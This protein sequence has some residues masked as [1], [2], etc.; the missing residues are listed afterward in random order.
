MDFNDFPP[1][2]GTAKHSPLVPSNVLL[3]QSAETVGSQRKLIPDLTTWMQCFSIYVTVLATQHPQFIPELLAYS[4]DIISASR[5]FKW[6]SWVIY[7]A[8]YRR[9]MAETGQKDW[10]KVDPSIYARC[11][12]GWARPPTWCTVCVTLDH[13]TGDCPYAAVQDRRVRR[14]T[15]YTAGGGGPRS[16][17]KMR[18]VCIKY[19]KYNGD[20]RHGETCKFRHVCSQCQGAHPRLQCK[21]QEHAPPPKEE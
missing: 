2:R 21:Q 5:H 7:N 4:R 13:D 1:A 8:T 17:P 6:P 9:H 11:F 14:P 12:T 10:S 16:A 18:P 3:V 19:N 15:P 20:C